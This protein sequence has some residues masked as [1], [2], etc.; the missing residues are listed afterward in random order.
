ME[1]TPMEVVNALNS[2]SAEGIVICVAV[3]AVSLGCSIALRVQKHF[4]AKRKA[5]LWLDE[6]IGQ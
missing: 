6:V 5:A 3:M 4:A 1:D 2:F